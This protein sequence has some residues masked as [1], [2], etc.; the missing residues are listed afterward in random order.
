MDGKVKNFEEHIIFLIL[1]Y[2]FLTYL[3][4]GDKRLSTGWLKYSLNTA[5]V[6]R[7]CE[8]LK[9]FGEATQTCCYPMLADSSITKRYHL[10]RDTELKPRLPCIAYS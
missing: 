3:D 2:L 4:S 5:N 9:A 10:L 7:V 8:V 1:R 6:S